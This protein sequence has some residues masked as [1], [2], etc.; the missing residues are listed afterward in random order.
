M[1]TMSAQQIQQVFDDL[2][3]STEEERDRFR[4]ISNIGG[5]EED[6]SFNFIRLDDVSS[7][8][9]KEQINAKLAPTS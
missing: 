2:R 6:Q 7:P 4:Q 1:T 5:Q 3:L 9:A 8:T